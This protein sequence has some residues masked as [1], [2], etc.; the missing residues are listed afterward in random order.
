MSMTPQKME[1]CCAIS[2]E[3][4]VIPK[5]MATYFTGSPVSIRQASQIIEDVSGSIGS[6]QGM[7]AVAAP[8]GKRKPWL[9]GWPFPEGTE[10]TVW[11]RGR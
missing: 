8:G 5:T 7:V 2:S 9:A 10:Q 6:L 3:E 1:N 4:N 11:F